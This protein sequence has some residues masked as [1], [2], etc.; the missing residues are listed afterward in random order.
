M[1]PRTSVGAGELA[2]DLAEADTVSECRH[3]VLPRGDL[4]E[5]LRLSR[6]VL[7]N[8]LDR[9]VSRGARPMWYPTVVGVRPKI[10]APESTYSLRNV[11]GPPEAL[12]VAGPFSTT[13]PLA[14]AWAKV[15]SAMIVISY[16]S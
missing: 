7:A 3:P 8:E 15:R 16:W 14:V 4:C 6:G 11:Q 1:G 2:G 10:V 9:A 13:Q 5:C 12:A